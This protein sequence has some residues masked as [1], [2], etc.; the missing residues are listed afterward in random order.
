[1]ADLIVIIILSFII[2]SFPS[3]IVLGKIFRQ[4]L[5]IREHGSGNT[6]ATNA[7]RVLGWKIG[8]VVALL[9]MF[10]GFAAVFWISR[11]SFFNGNVLPSVSFIAATLAVV[12]GHI[13]PVF[14]G[15]RGGRGFGAAVGAVIAYT[16][17]PAPF[18][19][20]AFL[21]ALGFTGWVSIC[22]A[23]A[24]FTLPLAYT[25]I[26]IIRDGQ[27]DIPVLIFYILTFFLTLFG[28]R[29]KMM[30]YFRGEADVFTKVR[31]FRKKGI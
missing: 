15:F 23:A 8:T 27:P 30:L 11:I 25:V 24:A 26:S 20:L 28:V 19:L 4:G 1:M 13:F 16:P 2:G 31:F 6:G 14:T 22:A 5:D 18:C 17:L 12:L 9:D 10:K 3:S 7:F 29:K 21:I